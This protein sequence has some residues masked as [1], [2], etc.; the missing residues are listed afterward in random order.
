MLSLNVLI[1]GSSNVNIEKSKY[2]NKNVHD[3]KTKE[4]ENETILL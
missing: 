2:I 1:V 4:K 3:P